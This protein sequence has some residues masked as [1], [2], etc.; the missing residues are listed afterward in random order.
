MSMIR[1]FIYFK[2]K[3]PH[4]WNIAEVLNGTVINFTYHDLILNNIKGVLE[5]YLNEKYIYRLLNSDDLETLH[6]FFKNQ[7][8]S[9]FKSFHPHSFDLASLKGI[10]KNKSYFLLG[11]FD[12]DDLI[13]YFFLR[14]FVNKKSFMGRLVD[15]K[16]QGQGISKRMAKILH[17]SAWSSNLRI[18]STI[19]MNN[20][21]SL[22]SQKAVN[23]YKLIKK[24]DNEYILLEYIKSEEKPL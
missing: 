14:C 6:N 2:T 12:Q 7:N 13:G 4:L 8:H 11:V 16:Y 9:Q 1:F 18:F 20:I 17:Q 22:M 23:N 5:N 3:F 19:S 15:I 10:L 24:L 21:S